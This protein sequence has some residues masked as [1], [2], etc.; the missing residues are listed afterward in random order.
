MNGEDEGGDGTAS[1][2]RDW[3]DGSL[4][5]DVMHRLH[6]WEYERD[7]L[8]S[9][10]ITERRGQFI[11][12]REVRK[13]SKATNGEGSAEEVWREEKHLRMPGTP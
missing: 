3:C 6:T 11:C 9:K 7:R 2:R 5:M 8:L 12:P 1:R 10:A 13:V 4:P